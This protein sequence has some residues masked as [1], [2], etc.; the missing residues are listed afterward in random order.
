MSCCPKCK[1]KEVEK[2]HPRTYYKCGSSDYDQ[3]SG[4]FKQG[5]DCK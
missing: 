5:K 2:S 3:R 1:A 4:T